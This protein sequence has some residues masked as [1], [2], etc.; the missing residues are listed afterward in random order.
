[1]LAWVIE[2]VQRSLLLARTLEGSRG[3]DRAIVC[4]CDEIQQANRANEPY[5]SIS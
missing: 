4:L 1:M 2:P 5:I 3:D